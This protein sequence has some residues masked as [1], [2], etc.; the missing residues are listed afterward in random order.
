MKREI[1]IKEEDEIEIEEKAKIKQIP[2]KLKKLLPSEEKL[3]EIHIE[4]F[5]NT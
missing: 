5:G 2:S 4:Q 3:E 1:P